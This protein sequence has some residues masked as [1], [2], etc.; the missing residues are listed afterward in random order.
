[1]NFISFI[2]FI[3][4]NYHIS[5]HDVT[6]LLGDDRLPP[7]LDLLSCTQNGGLP[8][9]EHGEFC[10]DF[11]HVEFQDLVEE[12]HLLVGLFGLGGEVGADALCV[13]GVGLLEV[14]GVQGLR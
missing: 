6:D 10:V 12:L 13:G 9:F 1:M 3:S 7:L 5:S 4:F 14:Q 8:F 11:F 2:S